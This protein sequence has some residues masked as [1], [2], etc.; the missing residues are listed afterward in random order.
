MLA[1]QELRQLGVLGIHA[2]VLRKLAHFASAKLGVIA[3]AALGDVMEQRRHIQHPVPVQACDQLT[4]QGIFLSVLG[5][6]E[7]AQVAHD[8]QSVLVH[9]IGMEQVV[10]HLAHDAAEHR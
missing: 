6:R 3:A 8:R 1:H 7:A 5:H 4:G 2:M 10:L 9:R